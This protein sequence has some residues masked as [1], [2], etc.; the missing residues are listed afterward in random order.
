MQLVD[1]ARAA[2]RWWSVRLAV[3]AGAA[4]GLVVDQPQILT[5]AVAVVPER[6]RPLAGAIAGLLVA[7]APIAARLLKQK[8]PAN[9]KS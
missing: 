1:D 2:W 8:E 4:A 3:L 5:G 6:W 7:V 9:G